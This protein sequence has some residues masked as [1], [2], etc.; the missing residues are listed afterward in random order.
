MG[1]G[2][3]RA[4]DVTTAGDAGTVYLIHFDTP[5]KHARHYT[6]WASDLER[7]V[8]EPPRGPRR[9]ADGSH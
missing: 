9:A 8:A 1:K 6:G 5:Y 2:R 7:R 4:P 3:H